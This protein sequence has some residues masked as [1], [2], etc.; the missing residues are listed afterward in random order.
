MACGIM[1]TLAKKW[2][3][4]EKKFRVVAPMGNMAVQAI[5]CHRGMLPNERTSSFSMAFIAELVH[6]IGLYRFYSE[7]AHRIV[8]VGAEHLALP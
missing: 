7:A 3:L 2:W 6:I 1:T 8:T 5:F 4:S